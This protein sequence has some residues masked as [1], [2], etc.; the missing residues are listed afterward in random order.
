M[1]RQLSAPETTSSTLTEGTSQLK[2]FCQVCGAPLKRGKL[3]CSP[4]CRNKA[5][6]GMGLMTTCQNCGKKIPMGRK[7]RPTKF[8]S[9]DCKEE[10]RAKHAKGKYVGW[11]KLRDSL[12]EERRKCQRCGAT[13]NLHVHHIDHNTR[14]N[15]LDNLVV[16]CQSCHISYHRLHD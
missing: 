12:K 5:R 16:L 7:N 6:A 8:C 3:F 10:Y 1:E 15:K 14:N 4:T 2:N 9:V 11:A 13:E